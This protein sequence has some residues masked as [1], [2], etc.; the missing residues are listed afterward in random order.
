MKSDNDLTKDE[1]YHN[2]SEFDEINLNN[3]FVIK[4]NVDTEIT[5]IKKNF[6]TKLTEFTKEETSSTSTS[7]IEISI[8][9]N[10]ETITRNN[11][12]GTINKGLFS[13][14]MMP[15]VIQENFENLDTK[16]YIYK[17]KLLFLFI[18]I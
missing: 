13:D 4:D 2:Y 8:S 14:D 1:N 10:N 6:I 11:S 15:N 3:D 16:E 9:S 5:K 17:V 18:Y 12:R 7:E